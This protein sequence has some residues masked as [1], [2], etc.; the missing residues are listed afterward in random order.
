M[1]CN[2]FLERA[3]D[4][5][6][7]IARRPRRRIAAHLASCDACREALA[8]CEPSPGSL[9]ARAPAAAP[10]A[11]HHLAARLAAESR[12]E[13]RRTRCDRGGM[14]LD[15][16]CCGVARRG[17]RVALDRDPS[18][19]SFVVGSGSVDP[20]ARQRESGC[21]RPNDRERARAGRAAL[22]E[23]HR[24]LEQVASA[25]R[26]AARPRGDGDRQEE[27]RVIDGRSTRAG[28]RSRRSQ[29]AA[30]RRRAC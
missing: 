24:G 5:V 21:S 8:T 18:T 12:P 30:W 25:S 29:T 7:T 9:R 2:E 16:R 15:C 19:R 27:P 10:A 26:L 23:G 4:L 13:R 22:R 17:G 14:G 1:T 3:A 28:R 11:W 20:T 6:E